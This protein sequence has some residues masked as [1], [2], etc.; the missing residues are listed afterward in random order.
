M[1]PATGNKDILI[2]LKFQGFR[3]DLQRIR[4]KWQPNSVLYSS[5][6][7]PLQVPQDSHGFCVSG[8]FCSG[9]G[10]KKGHTGPQMGVSEVTLRNTL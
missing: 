8:N 7:N 9:R 2:I 5:P 10:P 6:Y 1:G 3:G 4:D